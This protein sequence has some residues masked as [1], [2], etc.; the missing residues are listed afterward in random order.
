MRWPAANSLAR[1]GSRAAIAEISTS[2]RSIAGFTMASGAIC[3]APRMPKRKGRTFSISPYRIAAAGL[4]HQRNRTT[5]RASPLT[6]A[7]CG[8]A[9]KAGSI[10]KERKRRLRRTGAAV[11]IFV[12]GLV[13]P[14]AIQA[15]TAAVVAAEQA[16]FERIA[17]GLFG[18]LTPAEEKVI[19]GAPTGEITWCGDKSDEDDNSNDPALATQWS[20]D[21]AIRAGLI[22]W[23]LTD[24]SAA[25]YVHPAG[26]KL[27]GAK[28]LG[29]L[30][31]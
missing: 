15:Q 24:P 27:G 3:A 18:K 6:C 1:A 26:V 25:A 10:R 2:G 9:M 5:G 8:N 12:I 7:I 22:E 14:A 23:M 13:L 31:F 20:P 11:A 28:L 21:R 4:Q 30:E 17:S 16:A 19:R 29:P